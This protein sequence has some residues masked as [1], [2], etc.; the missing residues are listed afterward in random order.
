MDLCAVVVCG[1]RT[2]SIKWDG[3]FAAH[4][5]QGRSDTQL[6]SITLSARSF[7]KCFFVLFGMACSTIAR[8]LHQPVENTLELCLLAK[9]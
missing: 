8:L 5:C 4:I 9:S 6:A 2:Y 3:A 7:G 1:C